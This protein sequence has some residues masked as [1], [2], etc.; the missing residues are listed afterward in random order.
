MKRLLIILSFLTSGIPVLAQVSFKTLVPQ[1]SIIEGESFQVQYIIEG[2][3]QVAGFEAPDFRGFDKSAGPYLY[4]GSKPFSNGKKVRNT[5]YT[6]T[7]LHPGRFVIR[8]AIAVING[9]TYTSNDVIVNVISRNEAAKRARKEIEMGNPDYFLRPGEDPYEKIKKNL[10]VKVQ[11]NKRTCFVGEPV[12]ATFKLYSRLESRSDIVKNPGFYGFTVY[13][14]VSLSDRKSTTELING[15]MFDVHTIR[16][17]QLFPLQEGQFIVDGMEVKNT[18]EFS[19]SLINKK[20]EQEIIEGVLQSNTEFDT[21]STEGTEIFESTTHSEPVTV[22]VKPL[23]LHNRP[24]SFSGATGLFS[25][26]AHVVKDK[27]SKNE[28]GIMELSITGQGNFTQLDAPSIKWPNGVEGFEPVIRDSLDKTKIP[29]SGTRIFRYAFVSVNPGTHILPAVSMS[30][31]N[32]DTG[33]YKTVSTQPI[34]VYTSNET[35]SVNPAETS[36]DTK[37]ATIPGKTLWIAGSIVL[38][39]CTGVIIGR[40]QYKK[41]GK[42]WETLRKE[43]VPVALTINELLA[44]VY[45]QAAGTDKSFYATLQQTIWVFFSHHFNFSGSEMKKQVLEAKLKER[46]IAANLR[47]DLAIVLEQCDAGIYTDALHDQDKE[48]ILAMTK[49]LL[50]KLQSDLSQQA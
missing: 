15:R 34:E 5:V 40:R 44:P 28:Q 9:R 18:V 24:D 50:Q 42:E 19:R 43:P 1:Q 4:L 20:T 32:P 11:V 35:K 29:L 31:F 22:T 7:A 6:L 14:M 16:Q 2:G 41:R 47:A 27:L 12:V 33:N 26:H 38:L 10:F 25:L 8:G 48:T 3:E 30:Y 37:P 13:D 49:D 45:L 23:P 21:E 17:V 46:G 36:K 39:L